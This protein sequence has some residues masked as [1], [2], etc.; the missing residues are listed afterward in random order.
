MTFHD[1][2]RGGGTH[3]GVLTTWYSFLAPGADVSCVSDGEAEVRLTFLELGENLD[4]SCPVAND[5]NHLVCWVEALGPAGSMNQSALKAT[6]TLDIGP[7]P[8]AVC[9]TG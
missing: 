9:P 5:G 8:V 4:A 1:C 3:V 7:L 2:I 6:N